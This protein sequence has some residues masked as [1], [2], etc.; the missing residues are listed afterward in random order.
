[1]MFVVVAAVLMA[2][3][4]GPAGGMHSTLGSSGGRA[5]AGPLSQ[6]PDP[7][8]LAAGAPNILLIGDSVS[9]GPTGYALFVQ[10]LIETASNGSL[11]VV[12]HGGGFGWGG[13]MASS[14]NGAAKVR[15]CMGNNSGS[16]EAKAWS[17]ITYNAGL[18]DCAL[19][20]WVSEADYASNLRAVFE[21]L[22]PAAH[23]V[24]FVM[25]NPIA[26]PFP[27]K[28][29][30]ANTS[31]DG[32]TPQC[33]V[34]RNAIARQV[35]RE[36][37]GVDVAEIHDDVEAFCNA[38]P[39]APPGSPF[40]GH[41]YNCTLQKCPVACARDRGNTGEHFF[42][43]APYP[44][45]QQYTAIT[46]AE[47]VVRHIPANQIRNTSARAA[48]A[49]AAAATSTRRS[50]D[51][52]GPL[53]CQP[54]AALSKSGAP[55][56]LLIVGEMGGVVQRMLQHPRRGQNGT[57][58]GAFQ[59]YATG[60]LA[61]VQYM[62]P[63]PT[64]AAGASCIDT[65]VGR[66]PAAWD[67]I[68]LSFGLE[69]CLASSSSS[70]SSSRVNTTA[71]TQRLEIMFEA[72]SKGLATGG[73]LVWV[74]SVPAT[75]DAAASAC[76][77]KLNA[78]AAAVA[79]KHTAEVVD[80]HVAIESACRD[81]TAA[82]GCNLQA[83]GRGSSQLT[84]AGRTFL[85][86]AIAHAVI[87][88]LG[89]KWATF[90]PPP[91][92]PPPAADTAFVGLGECGSVGG[93][94]QDWKPLT[95]T[96]GPIRRA[97]GGCI[98]SA[99]C[100][101]ATSVHPPSPFT[102]SCALTVVECNATDPSQLFLFNATSGVVFAPHGAP[103]AA[104]LKPIGENTSRPQCFNANDNSRAT[105]AW[106]NLWYCTPTDS[107]ALWQ[108]GPQLS[109]RSAPTMCVTAGIEI[110][111][112]PPPPPPPPPPAPDPGPSL[113]TIGTYD[114]SG[115][116][117]TPF[118][119]HGDL[120]LVES[121]GYNT[122][123]PFSKP[124]YANCT[125]YAATGSPWN[126]TR[127]P[128]FRI[129]QMKFDSGYTRVAD[130]VVTTYVPET[131]DMS[132]CNAIV[133]NGTS[134]M[135]TLWVFGTNNDQRWGGAPRS[136]VHAFWSTDLVTW[137]HSVALNIAAFNSSMGGAYNVDVTSR[138]DGTSVMALEP[139]GSCS[140]GVQC[141]SYFAECVA[142]GSDLSRGWELLDG[143][144]YTAASMGEVDNPTI[145]Y[146]PSDG[147]YYLVTARA[148]TVTAV[149]P[150]L[151]PTRWTTMIGRSKDLLIWEESPHL[152]GFAC[153]PGDLTIIPGSALDKLGDQQACMPFCNKSFAQEAVIDINRS[154]MDFWE[155]PADEEDSSGAAGGGGGGGPKTFV[156]WVTGNQGTGAGTL[157]SC[158]HDCGASAAG[159]VDSSLEKWLQ[160]YFP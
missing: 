117:T 29:D 119:W 92:P 82:R 23:A 130:T 86:I 103:A 26:F 144:K 96:L 52:A 84:V 33:I 63:A 159:I 153:Q 89:A 48:A 46:V 11:G 20:Q 32:I 135:A 17:V 28:A 106:L 111:P 77:V 25:T 97:S 154:D 3:L 34:K 132:F 121:V 147:Y 42:N 27:V 80:A 54:P 118:M 90:K 129:R 157:H 57:G 158:P 2:H 39:I 109:L 131:A 4:V 115:G 93:G 67:T 53:V 91:P 122:V 18:H 61:V 45:G 112:A 14:A 47:A 78:A 70:S 38:G 40:A 105:G 37:G 128:Y 151:L 44:S 62:S 71:F 110:S 98:S 22:K 104:G 99:G 60:A 35:A 146:M 69:D 43:R 94:Q 74:T 79:A 8:P 138:P 107:I 21:T 59:T 108:H 51:E 143:S 114:L 12:Q 9:M 64:S 24:I 87:P 136:Q 75:G 15:D 116:E 16:L 13:Q 142:C 72:A 126:D 152:W 66:M 123:L 150:P 49:A 30:Y 88:H 41:F 148:H 160:S 120:L 85:S 31:L 76:V 10:D 102:P 83:A 145:R 65:W 113:R 73:K 6:C 100:G 50:D 141:V 55:N 134:E 155:V 1:M 125:E 127:C 68:A 149:A 133:R 36:V 58:T 156:V 7:K 139:A 95:E 19:T 56:V 5:V 101:P 81:S 137:N 140:G 124:V